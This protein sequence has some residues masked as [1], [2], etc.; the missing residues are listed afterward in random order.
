MRC[1]PPIRMRMKSLVRYQS[2]AKV[3]LLW[4]VFQ[5]LGL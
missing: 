1:E 3:P 2:E 4:E 5:A